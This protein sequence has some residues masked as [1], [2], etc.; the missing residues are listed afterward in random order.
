MVWHC[1]CFSCLSNPQSSSYIFKVFWRIF[2][3]KCRVPRSKWSNSFIN[4]SHLSF[5]IWFVIVSCTEKD[6]TLNSDLFTIKIHRDKIEEVC[7]IWKLLHL[8]LATLFCLMKIYGS[9]KK[10]KKKFQNLIYFFLY[11]FY[12]LYF[13]LFLGKK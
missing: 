1:T 2:V 5:L 6:K 9:W 13:S 12:F 11:S 7:E 10:K 3:N 4:T 8:L